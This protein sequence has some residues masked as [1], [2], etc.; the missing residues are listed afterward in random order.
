MKYLRKCEE[1]QKRKEYVEVK[2]QDIII[3][4]KSET[5]NYYFPTWMTGWMRTMK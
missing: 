3:F 5:Y 1:K 2:Q 4:N